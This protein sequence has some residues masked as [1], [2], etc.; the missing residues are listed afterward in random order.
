MNHSGTRSW[1]VRLVATPQYKSLVTLG[2]LCTCP[3]LQVHTFLGGFFAYFFLQKLGH[4]CLLDYRALYIFNQQH[5]RR[6]TKLL[7]KWVIDTFR[8]RIDYFP[9]YLARPVSNTQVFFKISSS[10]KIFKRETHANRHTH[11]SSLCTMVT[12][13]LKLKIKLKGSYPESKWMCFPIVKAALD[14]PV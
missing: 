5:W 12:S 2:L 4:V 7:F 13:L 8:R 10:W 1:L 9:K 14:L 6:L 3:L 11:F